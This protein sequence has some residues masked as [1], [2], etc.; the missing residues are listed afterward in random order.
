MG[1]SNL[2]DRAALERD[3]VLER[4]DSSLFFGDYRIFLNPYTGERFLRRE[5]YIQSQKQIE[6]MS[7]I[8]LEKYKP[9]LNVILAR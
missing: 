4:Q 7:K 2:K 1:N 3:W 8:I 6:E 5:H 9:H